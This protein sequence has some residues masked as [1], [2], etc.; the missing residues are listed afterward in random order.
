MRFK[1]PTC[2]NTQELSASEMSVVGNPIC[3]DCDAEM[4]SAGPHNDFRKFV[5]NAA[6]AIHEEWIDGYGGAMLSDNE[7][8][9]LEELIE[10]FFE[11]R[12]QEYWRES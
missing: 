6:I 5:D 4:E 7:F 9:A 2:D 3:E 10:T 1:C 11:G 8:K 12:T